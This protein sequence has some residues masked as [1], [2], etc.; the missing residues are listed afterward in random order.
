MSL[1]VEALPSLRRRPAG[2][3]GIQHLA[4]RFA[5]NRLALG[6]LILFVLILLTALFAPWVA[7]ACRPPVRATRW[8]RTNWA[9][10][11]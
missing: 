8:A 2:R 10:T 1:A 5:H 6:G 7:P 4:R 3:R 11:S 9:G